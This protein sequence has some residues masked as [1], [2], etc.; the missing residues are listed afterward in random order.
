MIVFLVSAL[1]A[2]I[3]ALVCIVVMMQDYRQAMRIC[4]RE[5]RRMDRSKGRLRVPIQ[6]HAAV[7]GIDI[8]DLLILFGEEGAE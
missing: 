7:K 2:G 6:E 5:R 8:E 3:T 4:E 1:T